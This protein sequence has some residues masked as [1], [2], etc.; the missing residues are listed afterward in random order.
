MFWKNTYKHT[1]ILIL[2]SFIAH[3]CYD[4]V[5]HGLVNFGVWEIQPLY[6]TPW[7]RRFLILE[8][9]ST[10]PYSETIVT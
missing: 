7:Q 3:F 9:Q 8:P 1:D 4:Q 5:C 6:A 10:A 2:K